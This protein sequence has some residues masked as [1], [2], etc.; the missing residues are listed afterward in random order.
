MKTLLMNLKE[1]DRLAMF[2]QVRDRSM[3]LIEASRRLGLSYRQAKRLWQQYRAVGDAGLVHGLRGRSSNNQ[4]GADSRRARAVALC[5]EHYAGFGPT[6]AA[7]Q[8]AARDGLVVDHETLR[9]WLICAGLWK[10]RRHV[11]RRHPRRTRRSCFGELVQFDGSDHHWFDHDGDTDRAREV[12]MVM[13]DDATGLTHARFFA[14]ETTAAAIT[15]AGVLNERWR[16]P[17]SHS[18]AQPVTTGGTTSGAMTTASTT[19]R[20]GCLPLGCKGP[21]TREGP[22]GT[23][24]AWFRPSSRGRLAVP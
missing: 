22:F 19:G 5:Q 14:A 17:R 1:R 7:E 4:R 10:P 8:L 16:G 3:T 24:R 15:A 9:G 11:R 20:M 21:S 18:S 12:L 23:V 2:R 13:V 6:L